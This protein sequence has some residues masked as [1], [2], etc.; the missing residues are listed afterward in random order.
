VKKEAPQAEA[1]QVYV[2][3]SVYVCVCPVNIVSHTMRQQLADRH[4]QVVRLLQAELPFS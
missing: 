1:V 3:V 2:F 4:R